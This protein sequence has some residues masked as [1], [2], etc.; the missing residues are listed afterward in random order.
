MSTKLPYI[1]SPGTVKTVLDKIIEARTPE[2]FTQDFLETKL[3]AKGGSARAVIPLLKRI[4]MIEQDGSPTE[5]YRKFRNNDTMGTAMASAIRHGYKEIFDRNEYAYDLPKPKIAEMV[6]EISGKEKGN[7]ADNYTVLTFFNLKEYAD[8]EALPD[9]AAVT[10]DVKDD[11]KIPESPVRIETPTGRV[12]ADQVAGQPLSLAY[13]INL[14]L[15]E[16]DDIKVFDAIFQSLNA[17]IL[18]Q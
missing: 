10:E 5:I 17:N 13:S 18:K 9:E 15:P 11:Q 12:E 14:H 2:R 1:A 3:G 6:N 16:T 7:S 8:F 4:G